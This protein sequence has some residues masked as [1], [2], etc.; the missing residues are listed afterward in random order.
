VKLH[1]VFLATVSPGAAAGFKPKVDAD[2]EAR[3]MDLKEAAA[4]PAAQLH[5]MLAEVLSAA[6]KA[7]LAAAFGVKL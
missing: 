3:W 2:H 4:L 5:S 6:H 1:T 7:D